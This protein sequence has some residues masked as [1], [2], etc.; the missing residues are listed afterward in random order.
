ME[1]FGKC[2]FTSRRPLGLICILLKQGPRFLGG[3][4]AVLLWPLFSLRFV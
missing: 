1:S 2:K 3:L 4:Q